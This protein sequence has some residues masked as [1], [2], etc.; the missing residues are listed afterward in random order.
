MKR[1][2]ILVA[3]VLASCQYSAASIISGIGSI[4]VMTNVAQLGSIL[5]TA[6]LND[7]CCFTPVPS[8]KYASSGMILRG[9]PGN[10]PDD[11]LYTNENSF[12]TILP[13]IVSTGH[14]VL[15]SYEVA[16]GLFSPPIEGGGQQSGAYGIYGLT[17]T[18]T[19]PVTQFAMTLSK[20]APNTLQLGERTVRSSGK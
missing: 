5:G 8:N 18:F 2:I 1:L 3:I 13:G 16:S 7:G 15:P 10:S 6:N 19:I 4:G 9:V 14:A 11:Q 20:M 17:A 12:S